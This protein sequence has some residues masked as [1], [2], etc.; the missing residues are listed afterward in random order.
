[1]MTFGHSVHP[2]EVKQHK[3]KNN[4]YLFTVWVYLIN[5]EYRIRH[6]LFIHE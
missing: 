3:I 2:I 5:I 6:V 1:M 4:E